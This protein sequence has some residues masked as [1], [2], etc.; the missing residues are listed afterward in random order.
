MNSQ[1][2]AKWT[3]ALQRH[4]TR[5]RTPRAHPK[6]GENYPPSDPPGFVEGRDELKKETWAN[7]PTANTI[8]KAP[9]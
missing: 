3:R 8:G 7:R 9:I 2:P 6:G 1:E 4:A 5:A